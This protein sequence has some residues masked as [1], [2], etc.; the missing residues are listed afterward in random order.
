[1][2]PNTIVQYS[3]ANVSLH[4]V[5]PFERGDGVAYSKSKAGT[6]ILEGKYRGVILSEESFAVMTT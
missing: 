2:L 4:L 5:S 6:F 1:M 3:K